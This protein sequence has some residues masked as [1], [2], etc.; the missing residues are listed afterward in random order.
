MSTSAGKDA[1]NFLAAAIITQNGRR[2]CRNWAWLRSQADAEFGHGT[3]QLS[4]AVDDIQAV[5][6]FADYFEKSPDKLGAGEVRRFQLYLL[7][8]KKLEPST[9]KIRLSA[10]RFLYSSQPRFLSSPAMIE[11]P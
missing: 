1:G 11:N 5:K 9:V 2:G 6:R 7:K 10:L 3:V 4:A 8:E